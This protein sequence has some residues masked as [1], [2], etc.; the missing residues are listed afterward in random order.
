MT[1]SRISS[2]RVAVVVA[3]GAI[4]GVVALLVSSAR[5]EEPDLGP[6]ATASALFEEGRSLVEAGEWEAGCAKLELSMERYAAAS[7]LLNLARCSEHFG[8]VATAWARYKRG[9]V[10]SRETP[11]EAR[12]EA[13]ARVA[14]EG[15]EAMEPRLPRLSVTVDTESK[16]GAPPGL[17]IEEGG[18]P[19]A[20]G[21]AVVLDPGGRTV[22]VSAPGYRPVERTV[23]LR[24]GE[25]TEIAI[26]LEAE[27]EPP[28]TPAKPDASA[29]GKAAPPAA[30]PPTAAGGTPWWAWASGGLGLALGGVSAAF[31]I[32]AAS[33]ASSLEERCG[34]DL[35]CDEDPSFDPEPD[36]DRKNR[37]IYLAIGFGAGA[38]VAIGVAIVGFVVGSSDTS[39]PSAM[40]S[41]QLDPL[42]GTTGLVWVR[43]F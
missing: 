36:N 9:L 23:D 6:D 34:G 14:T 39:P 2:S 17:R 41:V 40:P 15:I 16:A 4:A 25:T 37:D 27:P 11:G 42:T 31:A 12:R 13:L 1:R 19:L 32:D 3:S 43:P 10:L 28:P 33:V 35:V 22:V 24:E 26:V 30:P 18:K 8:Q 38:A 7:T 20:V 5:A 29:D 21:S